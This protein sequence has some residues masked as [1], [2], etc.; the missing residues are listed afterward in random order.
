MSSSSFPSPRNPVTPLLLNFADAS[1]ES[2]NDDDDDDV[3]LVAV[4]A[5]PCNCSNRILF[6]DAKDLISCS[7]CIL[8]DDESV[9]R[10]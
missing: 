5:V 2:L 7:V 3:E 8:D 9:S 4:I 10:M 1:F 6:L